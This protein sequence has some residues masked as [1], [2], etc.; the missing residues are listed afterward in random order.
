MTNP[1]PP[2]V[3]TIGRFN[4]PTIGHY[5]VFDAMK[6]YLRTN[7]DGVTNAFIVIVDGEKT[8]DDK[9]RNPLT[10]AER[11]AFL[12]ASDKANGIKIL[13][14][15]NGFDAFKAV[16]DEGFEPVVIAAGSDRAPHYLKVLDQYF[17]NGA[18]G[19]PVKHKA[20]PGLNREPSDDPNAEVSVTNVSGSM[21]RHAAS[22]GYFE[23]FAE[24]VGLTDKPKLAKTLFD[25]V[26]ASMKEGPPDG[27]V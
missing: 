23:E 26:R 14:A 24:M 12:E 25:K 10:G 8:G 16:I 4:P 13:I 1:R 2:A 6:R 20:L 21:A 19:K 22:L 27:T 7:K 18:D 5:A 3:V 17:T 15:K 9:T 11:K